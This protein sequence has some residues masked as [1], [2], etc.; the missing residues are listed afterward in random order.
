M[1]FH[2]AASA[3]VMI[4]DPSQNFSQRFI[5]A[6]WSWWQRPMSYAG[7]WVMTE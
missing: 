3:I 6:N 1:E 5:E 4:A 7:T 2:H